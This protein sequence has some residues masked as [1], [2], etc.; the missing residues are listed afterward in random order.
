MGRKNRKNKRINRTRRLLGFLIK[1][2]E[3]LQGASLNLKDTA[4]TMVQTERDLKEVGEILDQSAKGGKIL[5]GV[6]GVALA[7]ST[8]RLFK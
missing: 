7:F 5:N 6:L 2:S 1:S 3:D 4:E 8:Y